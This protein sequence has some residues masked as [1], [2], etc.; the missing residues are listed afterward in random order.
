MARTHVHTHKDR[1]KRDTQMLDF[2]G[3]GSRFPGLGFK[4]FEVRWF[5]GFMPLDALGCFLGAQRVPKGSPKASKVTPE[6]PP[7][8][9]FRKY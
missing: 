7:E 5:E 9:I 1:N 6:E 8:Y 4:C 3:S 2:H